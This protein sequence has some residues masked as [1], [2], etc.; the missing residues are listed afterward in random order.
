MNANIEN[1]AEFS[2]AGINNEKKVLLVRN[3]DTNKLE[4]TNVFVFVEDIGLSGRLSDIIAGIY[5]K[6]E[7]VSSAEN[8]NRDR[9]TEEMTK[10]LAEEKDVNNETKAA[11]ATLVT[12]HLDLFILEQVSNYAIAEFDK[13][14]GEGTFASIVITKYGRNIVPSM[15]F[16]IKVITF[17]SEYSSL[18]AARGITDT[19]SKIKER[20]GV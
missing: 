8:I 7:V 10:V 9:L 15:L 2:F 17:I 18:V 5:K 13:V 16:I 14:F 20:L 6:L 19:M 1:N 12:T 11:V 3:I 4:K